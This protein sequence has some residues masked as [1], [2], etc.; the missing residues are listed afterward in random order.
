MRK[1]TVFCYFS[2]INILQVFLFRIIFPC[3]Y[4]VIGI[5]MYQVITFGG[6]DRANPNSVDLVPSLYLASSDGDVTPQL[7]A[8]LYKDSLPAG[9]F[10]CSF[11][12]IPLA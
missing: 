12:I 11:M 10:D 3:A 8:L 6:T 9:M 7:T 1:L 5:V 2:T 4:I